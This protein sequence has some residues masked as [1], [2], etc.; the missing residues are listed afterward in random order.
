MKRE[1]GTQIIW[2]VRDSKQFAQDLNLKSLELVDR[3]KKRTG[4]SGICLI[5]CHPELI[6]F[7]S[8]TNH[9]DVM[10]DEDIRMNEL[11]FTL[12]PA[13]NVKAIGLMSIQGLRK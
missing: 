3:L 7:I 11:V 10:P 6:K 12:G 2:S 5:K 13:D 9:W 8:K 4:R 1:F